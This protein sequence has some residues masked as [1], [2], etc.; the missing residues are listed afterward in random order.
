MA[1]P[2]L[3]CNNVMVGLYLLMVHEVQNFSQVE[4][5]NP[6]VLDG[7]VQWNKQYFQEAKTISLLITFN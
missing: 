5:S 1:C 6:N 7:V 4:S 2:R 3:V